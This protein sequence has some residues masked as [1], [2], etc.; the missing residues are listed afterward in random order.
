MYVLHYWPDTA[1]TMVRLV[2]EDLGLPYEAR[3]IDR[4]GGELTSAA[5]RTMNP[6]GQIP[7]F[8]TPDGMMF[9]T[10]A[11]LL[12]LS[13]RH[14]LGPAAK[15]RAQFLK[16]LFFISTNLHTNVLQLFYPERTAGPD[17]TAAVVSHAAAKVAN[18]LTILN[19][20]VDTDA[21]NFLSD[22]QPT[23]LGYYLAVL[24]RWIA[25]DFPS[26]NYPALHRILVFLEQ[27]PATQRCAEAEALGPTP[28]T[29]PS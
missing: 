26:T 28:F 5:Y 22:Q 15:D 13:E 24:M 27:R 2:L 20:L 17:N 14:G 1:S 8:E 29:Q 6:L 23:L 25:N 19:Q 3:L 18:H 9:E 12:Y 16:W 4:E 10:A 7:A 21:P 11:I